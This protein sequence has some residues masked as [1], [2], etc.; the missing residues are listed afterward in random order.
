MLNGAMMK[1]RNAQAMIATARMNRKSDPALSFFWC[2][3]E[4]AVE[5]RRRE[6]RGGIDCLFPRQPC[7]SRRAGK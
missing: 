6:D 2:F 7:A 1:L 3:A 4:P 5:R